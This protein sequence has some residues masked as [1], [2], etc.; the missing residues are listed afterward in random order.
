[1]LNFQNLYELYEQQT[2]DASAT[3]TTIGKARVNDTHKELVGIH[4]WYFAEKTKTFTT[5][6]NDYQYDLPFDYGRMVALTIDY[7]DVHYS[8]TEVSS[9]DEW[10]KL[11]I[12]RKTET[13]DLPEYYHVTGDSIEIWPI[14]TTAGSTNNA[15]FYYTKRV[16]DMQYDN[17]VTGTVTLTN[18]DATVEGAGGVAFTAA[19]VGRWI[20]G[21]L[22]ARWYEIASFTDSDTFELKKSFEGTTASSLAYTIGEMPL[23][24]EEY[25][26]LL[27][28]QPVAQYWM[29]KKE[30]QTSSY[31]QG[32]YDAG[33]QQFFNAYSKRTRGQLLRPM[34]RRRVGVPRTIDGAWL[35]PDYD[36]LY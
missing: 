25:H 36:F 18:N 29:M 34:T 15:T 11:H 3:N 21:D 17:Y 5:G 1:M 27:W 19:M 22:D 7:A 9:H 30:L 13:S 28:Y 35:D 10:Q 33:K 14:P 12:Y 4:D 26:S 20:R 8:L 24:P 2:G 23:I 32:L 16:V 31:F 6:G